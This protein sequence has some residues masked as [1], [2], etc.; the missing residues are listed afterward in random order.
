MDD[1]DGSEAEGTVQF[2]LD[3]N[4]YE[5]DLSEANQGKLRAALKPFLEAGRKQQTLP[6]AEAST[7]RSTQSRHQLQQIRAWAKANGYPVNERSR[8]PNSILEAYQS[9]TPSPSAGAQ[10]QALKLLSTGSMS[11]EGPAKATMLTDSE[12]AKWAHKLLE[13][14]SE[15]PQS[16]I[17]G[18]DFT[19]LQA[20]LKTKA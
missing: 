15:L 14:E 10:G 11:S 3:S 12:F 16:D 1:L 20:D 9:G 17:K 2:A 19:R 13:D 7:T 5:I 6:R 4:V 8:I 18:L